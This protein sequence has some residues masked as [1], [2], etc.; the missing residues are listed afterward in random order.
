LALREKGVDFERIDIDLSAVP[1]WYEKLSPTGKVP[2]LLRG[3]EKVW[4]S[5]II[6]EYL[7]EV[8]PDP[9]LMPRE[10]GAR[11]RARIWMDYANSEFLPSFY[12]L[13]TERDERESEERARKLRDCLD[14]MEKEGLAETPGSFWMGKKVSLVDLSFYPFFERFPA[15]E[16]YRGFQIPRSCPKILHWIESMQSRPSVQAEASPP[17]FYIQAYARYAGESQD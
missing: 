4:E 1:V 12:Q 2:L 10:P 16:H 3:E 14:Y 6:N 11:A 5:T 8:F 13:L 15:L 7:E 9:P 17:D